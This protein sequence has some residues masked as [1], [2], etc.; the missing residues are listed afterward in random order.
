MVFAAED[1]KFFCTSDLTGHLQKPVFLIQFS[2][3]FEA[4]LRFPPGT[5]QRLCSSVKKDSGYVVQTSKVL[6]LF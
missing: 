2:F 4:S 5:Q 1:F 6:W 3:V